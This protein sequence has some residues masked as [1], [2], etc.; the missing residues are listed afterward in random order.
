MPEIDLPAHS[1]A[2]VSNFK[3]LQEKNDLSWKNVKGGY[4]NNTIN[5]ALD[6]TWVF[7]KKV[8]S[9]VSKIFDF[10]YFHIG[11][12]ERPKNAWTRSP[13]INKLMKKNN[14]KNIDNIQDYFVNRIQNIL[15]IH[16][17]KSAAWNEAVTKSNES[18][19]INKNCLIFAW[20]NRKKGIEAAKK[21]FD[22]I[23]CPAQ[24]CYLDMAHNKSSHENGLVWAGVIDTKD[25]FLWN[26]LKNLE[27][28]V[29]NKII[30]IQAQLW[31]E[32]ITN[33]NFMDI[34]I[35]P[36]L[37]A[38]AEVAWSKKTRNWSEFRCILNKIIK[39]THLIGW[40]NH[41]Y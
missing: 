35:N 15:K 4:L 21:G 33:I 6:Y 41:R 36:R 28:K 14:I 17:K 31:S 9:E 3:K 20:E 8:V 19:N 22:V 26:P 18:I 12:D 40:K 24:K 39:L 10:E 16:K 5:P 32:T 13:S 23:M 38:I 11:V 7:V 34:M 29:K 27:N 37:I 1:W 25:I 2:L 30:G